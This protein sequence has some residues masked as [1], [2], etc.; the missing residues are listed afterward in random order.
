M[1]ASAAL[2]GWSNSIYTGD[3]TVHMANVAKALRLPSDY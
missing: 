2:V 3:P 1:A